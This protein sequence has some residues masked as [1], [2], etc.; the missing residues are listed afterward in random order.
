[1]RAPAPKTP[2]STVHKHHHCQPGAQQPQQQ[3]LWQYNCQHFQSCTPALL[4]TGA[5]AATPGCSS[6]GLP[7]DRSGVQMGAGRVPGLHYTG[8]TPCCLRRPAK[9]NS[10]TQLS[11]PGHS[12]HVTRAARSSRCTAAA[13]GVAAAQCAGM[14]RGP[15]T[16]AAGVN[17]CSCP[18]LARCCAPL[19]PACLQ[20]RCFAH[21]CY[22][23]ICACQP[24]WVCCMG[25]CQALALLQRPTRAAWQQQQRRPAGWLAAAA[26]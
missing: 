21:T 13:V 23:S 15:L 6:H 16:A 3:Q 1:L 8:Y 12:T 17:H 9:K 22:N 24:G 10:S 7:Y 20:A 26:A 19:L 2:C 18:A 25:P 14:A 5:H 4:N 11:V